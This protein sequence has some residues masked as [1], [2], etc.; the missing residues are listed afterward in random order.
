MCVTSWEVVAEKEARADSF[1]A[2]CAGSAQGTGEDCWKYCGEVG[3]L[4]GPRARLGVEEGGVETGER[5]GGTSGSGVPFA[6]ME[7]SSPA[8]VS[9]V[10]TGLSSVSGAPCCHT[11]F[12]SPG[13]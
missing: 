11:L 6:E 12:L 2:Q 13:L 9:S 4:A 5:L 7:L 1:V 10:D 3:E 8:T